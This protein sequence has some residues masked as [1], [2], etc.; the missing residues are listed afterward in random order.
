M[1]NL[2]VDHGILQFDRVFAADT[3][4]AVLATAR[5]TK[6][7]DVI[8]DTHAGNLKITGGFRFV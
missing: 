3:T 7:G 1:I 2:D 4:D 8:I 6:K 5:E